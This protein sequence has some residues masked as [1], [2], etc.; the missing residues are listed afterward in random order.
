MPVEIVLTPTISAAAIYAAGDAIGGQLVFAA[1]GALWGE[2]G[3]ITKVVIVDDDR[4]MA[5]IDLVLFDRT[6]TATADNAPFD[7]SDADLENCIGYIDVA[8]TDY[9]AF[10]DNAVAAKASGL[11]MPF[12]FKLPAGA[13]ALYGQ[14]VVRGTP[15]Y[16][17]I[18]DL[19]IKIT[20]RWAQLEWNPLR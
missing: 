5:P 3:E 6:F 18:G 8:A 13:V 20:V 19:T 12:D 7:P 2:G 14:M 1:A 10:V 9:G 16:T 15:T 11:R 17:A 4:E